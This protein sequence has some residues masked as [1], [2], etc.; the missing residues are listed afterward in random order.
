M[1]QKPSLPAAVR[2]EALA[3]IKQLGF[4]TARLEFPLPARS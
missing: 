4:D 3:R 2:S 1:S